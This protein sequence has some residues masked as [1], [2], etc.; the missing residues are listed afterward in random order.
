MV[1]ELGAAFPPPRL[2]ATLANDHGIDANTI[3]VPLSEIVRD[4]CIYFQSEQPT[5]HDKSDENAAKKVRTCA[6]NLIEAI[7]DAPS[8]FVPLT[9]SN[10]Q[11]LMLFL[12]NLKGLKKDQERGNWLL[13]WLAIGLNEIVGIQHLDKGMRVLFIADAINL[14]F[15]PSPGSLK[16]LSNEVNESQVS[17]ILYRT[18]RGMRI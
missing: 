6:R 1:I 8:E 5:P 2:V 18:Q 14:L 16:L 4:A 13:R 17:A 10:K 12:E 9:E 3:A 15:G 7:E 11:R